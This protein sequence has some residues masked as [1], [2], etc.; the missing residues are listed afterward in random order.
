M[1]RRRN[2]SRSPRRF[3]S[4]RNNLPDPQRPSLRYSI[5]PP[6]DRERRSSPN[7]RYANRDARPRQNWQQRLNT[8]PAREKY[9]NYRPRREFYGSGRSPQRYERSPTFSLE[10]GGTRSPSISPQRYPRNRF[11]RSPPSPKR[12]HQLNRS[13]HNSWRQPIDP[14]LSSTV[15]REHRETIRPRNNSPSPR[16]TDFIRDNRNRSLSGSPMDISS[17]GSEHHSPFRNTFK[18]VEVNKKEMKSNAPKNSTHDDSPEIREL[19]ANDRRVRNVHNDSNNS[20]D[21]RKSRWDNQQTIQQTLNPKELLI[22]QGVANPDEALENIANLPTFDLKLNPTSVDDDAVQKQLQMLANQERLDALKKNLPLGTGLPTSIAFSAIGKPKATAT[23]AMTTTNSTLNQPVSIVSSIPTTSTS[24]PPVYVML[25]SLSDLQQPHRPVYNVPPPNLPNEMVVPSSV[26][27]IQTSSIGQ[28][29]G[30]FV[31]ASTLPSGSLQQPPIVS[32][33]I[34]PPFIHF[35]PPMFDQ[36][37]PMLPDQQLDQTEQLFKA[38]ANLYRQDLSKIQTIPQLMEYM[39]SQGFD[40]IPPE[41]PV[42]LFNEVIKKKQ[43]VIGVSSLYQIICYGH[44]E[45]ESYY[46]GQCN[47]WTTV[48]EMFSHL[49]A[50]MHRMNYLFRNYKVF[51]QKAETITDANDRN[52]FLSLVCQKVS[53]IEGSGSCVNRM[54]C[55]LNIE[56][57]RQV[58]PDYNEFVDNS[59]KVIDD[60]DFSQ[61]NL[62]PQTNDQSSRPSEQQSDLRPIQQTGTNSTNNSFT[63]QELRSTSSDHSDRNRRRSKKRS[64]KESR[65]REKKRSDNR[66]SDRRRSRSRSRK[67]ENRRRSRSRSPARQSQ[68]SKEKDWKKK[69]DEF[70]EKTVKNDDVKTP[71][72][73]EQ[74]KSPAQPATKR[75]EVAVDNDKMTQLRK[76]HG[77]VL[78]LQ[79][80]HSKQGYIV[81]QMIYD[82]AQDMGMDDDAVGKSDVIQKALPEFNIV[83][84]APKNNLPQLNTETANNLEAFGLSTSGVQQLLTKLNNATSYLGS[85]HEFN[86]MISQPSPSIV[87]LQKSISDLELQM[88]DS[89]NAPNLSFFQKQHADLFAQLQVAKKYEEEQTSIASKVNYVTP[90]TWTTNHSTITQTSN[91]PI[92]SHFQHTPT[93]IGIFDAQK[94]EMEWTK[95][96]MLSPEEIDHPVTPSYSEEEYDHH[97]GAGTFKAFEEVKKRAAHKAREQLQKVANAY[98]KGYYEKF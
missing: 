97:Y 76:G 67:R 57:I 41:D 98:P 78:E 63:D 61:T 25:P 72:S 82:I 50:P 4:V 47:H 90:N 36:P 3:I 60:L 24:I 52:R 96:Y 31:A 20:G 56:A 28:S 19:D 11:S 7:R 30:S 46:C 55:I 35:P 87:Q 9:D 45:L 48:S 29:V 89:Q 42:L 74:T 8:P 6:R 27:R 73:S 64:S 69:T 66:S 23:E 83:D 43:G 79:N 88:I 26:S 86:S 32:S 14:R 22:R 62:N 68:K 18:P 65:Y 33:M 91:Q 85:Q 92:T 16:P 15:Y 75:R 12:H 13:P 10:G 59:W 54:R 17:N 93:N 81:R 44:P 84:E 37:P 70:I 94:V 77:V 39:W 34:P 49:T 53:A 5:S 38:R 80:L 71:S 2:D 40:P 1:Y 51:H 58:W 21:R 95:Y